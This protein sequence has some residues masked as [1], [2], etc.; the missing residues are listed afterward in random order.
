LL[1]GGVLTLWAPGRWPLGGFQ[2]GVYALAILTIVRLLWR[3]SRLRGGR[4]L[5]PMLTIPAIGTIQIAT[6][7]TTYFAATR[8][9]LLDWL[10]NASL[11]FLAAQLFADR[12]TRREFL[13]LLFYFAFALS[14]LAV[15]QE[16]T[17]HGKVFWLFASGYTDRVMGPFISPNLYAAFIELV[18][19]IGLFYAISGRRP[20]MHAGMCGFMLASVLVGASRAG[21]IVSAAE[22]V[23][24]LAAARMQGLV[25]ARA[26]VLWAGSLA[27]G[28]AAVV[29]S[30]GGTTVWQRLQE[31][32]PYGVRREMVRSSIDMVRERPWTG[33]G[34]GTW[35]IHYPRFAYYDDGT[36]TLHA[37]ND[38]V[39]WAAEGGLPLLAV[40]LAVAVQTVRPALRSV[41]GIGVVAVWIHAVVDSPL[42]NP[43]VA[44]WFFL[45]C[46]ILVAPQQR[47]AASSADEP[48]FR[49]TKIKLP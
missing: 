2:A 4:L 32:D 8:G 39:E 15:A 48:V 24:V 6:R 30:S 37:H 13:R 31:R 20:W 19:P 25:N 38:W 5:V 36:I 49:P 18:L 45:M 1:F 14:V 44:G 46:G 23:A 34:L 26:M 22:V 33:F 16:R 9:S 43:I 3:G 42:Q 10:T 29:A 28:C 47:K 12:T 11:V 40:L 27:I 35:S 21:L 7:H 41:W 17:S